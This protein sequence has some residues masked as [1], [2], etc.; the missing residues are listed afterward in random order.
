MLITRSL[1]LAMMCCASTLHI[2][3][4]CVDNR[5]LLP[6]CTRRLASRDRTLV[7]G[8]AFDSSRACAKHSAQSTRRA[9]SLAV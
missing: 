4:A 3:S 6:H 5:S 1:E 9:P 2:W 7:L 8:R